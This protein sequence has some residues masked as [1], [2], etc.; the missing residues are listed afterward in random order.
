MQDRRSERAMLD[1][2][3]DSLRRGENRVLVGAWRRRGWQDGAAGVC[4]WA[5]IRVSGGGSRSP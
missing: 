5:G 1:R 2:L 3:L 4:G